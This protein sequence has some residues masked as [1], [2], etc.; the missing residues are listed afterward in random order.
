MT[1]ISRGCTIKAGALFVVF[2]LFMSFTAIPPAGAQSSA[3][4]TFATFNYPFFGGTHI[5]VDL[6]GD[7]KLDLAG[8][9]QSSAAIMLNKGDG[10]FQ[11]KVEY[12][13]AGATQA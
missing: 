7:G 2:T 9:A 11:P 4:A 8:S 6:N 1:M 13:V 10:T 12:P 5:A 3:S